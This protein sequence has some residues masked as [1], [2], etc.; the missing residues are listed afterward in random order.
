MKTEQADLEEKQLL[1]IPQLMGWTINCVDIA[2][3]KIMKR[4][5]VKEKMYGKNYPEGGTAMKNRH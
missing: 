1:E 2:A 3:L 4:E 5:L